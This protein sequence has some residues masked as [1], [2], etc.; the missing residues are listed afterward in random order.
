MGLFS[1]EAANRAVDTS[2]TGIRNAVRCIYPKGSNTLAPLY[3]DPDLTEQLMSDMRSDEAGYFGLCYLEDGEYRVEITAPDGRTVLY[4]AEDILVGST[5]PPQSWRDYGTLPALLDDR[6]LSY[7][8]GTG[9]LRV[10]PG[11]RVRVNATDTY[12]CVLPEGGGAAQVTTAGGVRLCET[13]T[14]FSSETRF[15]E[16]VARGDHF[17]TGTTVVAGGAVYVF[18]DDGNTDLP[19]LTGWR[20]VVSAQNDADLTAAKAKTDL[21]SVTQAV[22]LDVLPALVAESNTYDSVAAGLAATTDGAAFFVATGPGLQVYRNNAGVGTFLGWHGEI[23][24]DDVVALAAAPANIPANSILRTR[25][26]GFVYKVA[27]AGATDHHVELNGKRLYVIP[28]KGALDFAAWGV[29]TTGTTNISSA[30]HKALT[31]AVSLDTP[32]RLPPG[33]LRVSSRILFFNIPAH[34][35]LRIF[36]EGGSRIEIDQSQSLQ[37]RSTRSLQT[38]LIGD[39]PR[40]AR[41]IDL[42]DT[43]G[44][45][46]GDLLEILSPVIVE[47]GWS[48]KKTCLRRVGAVEPGGRVILDQA[49]DFFFDASEN[50]AVTAWKP[51]HVH[52]SGVNFQF[53][54]FAHCTFLYTSG[55]VE[56]LYAEGATAAWQDGAYCD[57]FRTIGCD[58]FVYDHVVFNKFRY[59][60]AINASRNVQVRNF[61]AERVRHLDSAAWSQDILFENGVGVET[62]GIIQCHPCIRPVFRNIHDSVTGTLYGLG[63]RGMGE[64]VENC[65]ANCMIGEPGQNTNAPLLLPDYKDMA[66]S[67]TRVIRN[68][69][70][71]VTGIAPGAEGTLIV[72]NCEVPYI[73]AS[74]GLS[75]SNQMVI[76][77]DATRTTEIYDPLKRRALNNVVSTRPCATR[78]KRYDSWSSIAAGAT[79]TITAITQTSPAVVTSPGH[80]LV[81][82]DWLRIREVAGMSQINDELVRVANPTADTFELVRRQNGA[83]FSTSSYGTYTGGGIWQRIGSPHEIQGISNGTPC[84]LTRVSHGL[85]DGDCV[86]INGVAGM[87]ALNNRF[88]IVANATPDTVELTDP[89]TGAP[90]DASGYGAYT[91][92]GLMTRHYKA[93]TVSAHQKANIGFGD[94]LWMVCSVYDE[95]NSTL[96]PRPIKRRV[97][98]LDM[99]GAVV[100]QTPRTG[101]LRVTL[102]TVAGVM[103][104]AYNFMVH[105]S[106]KFVVSAPTQIGEPVDWS[107]QMAVT[108][109]NFEQNS[110]TEVTRMG[111]TWSSPDVNALYY[112]GFD[113]EIQSRGDTLGR[114]VGCDVE[115]EE[116]RLT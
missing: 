17:S 65:S 16:A 79:G 18:A 78:V 90:V 45:E 102:R 71:P 66:A 28:Q 46:V 64:V 63:L 108:V 106:G 86:Y 3:R 21:V 92:G 27:P 50:V 7:A 115:I 14:R 77:D 53:G 110:N 113:V 111:A 35:R 88:F 23:L 109:S 89:E 95:T 105:Y 116:T 44:L 91:G 10:W 68:F 36:S 6:L 11:M 13:G 49:L 59:C 31:T 33:R 39:A 69:R 26:E 97:K 60:P 2:G 94:K 84:V 5:T 70:S 73:D 85:S 87:T 101:T 43:T 61:R 103:Q 114:I 98:V 32:L 8:D 1:H 52:I 9:R 12:F 48:Y 100:D 112:W 76:V 82:G 107:N 40:G 51:C 104:Y 22:N 81:A 15:T 93:V 99:A 34:T 19:G 41:Y 57:G 75:N 47:T 72:E 96:A 20:R 80:G 74:E 25:S 54:D 58:Q 55:L 56:K 42:A 29:D 67:M 83:P 38:V 4:T 62:D 30:L 37:F 24:F